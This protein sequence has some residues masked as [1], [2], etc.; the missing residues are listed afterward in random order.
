M[1][2]LSLAVT[3]N[4]AL[5]VV[6]HVTALSLIACANYSLHYSRFQIQSLTIILYLHPQNELQ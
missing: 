2:L 6:P 1:A 4:L 5:T 3:L